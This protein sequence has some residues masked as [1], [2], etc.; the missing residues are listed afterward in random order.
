MWV[1]GFI[2]W[3]CF[4][5][6]DNYVT[7]TFPRRTLH[8]HTWQQ[9][10]AMSWSRFA[11]IRAFTWDESASTECTPVLNALQHS[12]AA[13]CRAC[14]NSIAGSELYFPQQILLSPTRHHC[15]SSKETKRQRDFVLSLITSPTISLLIWRRVNIIF[16][17]QMNEKVQ[18]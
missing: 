8:L 1:L 3:F 16:W 2:F 13:I 9:V 4:L 11:G 6:I 10:F 7:S 14:V 15:R 17:R 5:F 18:N 12:L